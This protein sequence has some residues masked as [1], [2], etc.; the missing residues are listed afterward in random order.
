MSEAEVQNLVA[1]GSDPSPVM[2]TGDFEELGWRV[3]DIIS[4]VE[5]IAY[6]LYERFNGVKQISVVQ[7]VRE[8]KEKTK[9]F[10]YDVNQLEKLDDGVI[11][12][13][14]ELEDCCIPLNAF[15]RDAMTGFTG[16]THMRVTHLNGCIEYHV[17]P[18]KKENKI[19]DMVPEG[20]WLE[21]QRLEVISKPG[22]ITAAID[23]AKGKLGM[24]KAEP[25][26]I[27][28]PRPTGCAPTEAGSCYW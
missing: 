16:I 13:K 23:K 14:K 26:K 17:I 24:S 21:C 18:D 12:I 6:S 20:S 2:L 3:R 9:T 4:G 1:E 10:S 7:Q 19:V 25:D 28:A 27:A 15:V 8:G 11:H 5:G 22:I